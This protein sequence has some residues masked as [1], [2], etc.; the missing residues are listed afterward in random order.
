M[1][2]NT[3]YVFD[4]LKMDAFDGH[5]LTSVKIEMLPENEMNLFF[6][7]DVKKMDVSKLVKSFSRYIDYEDIKSENVRGIVPRKWMEKLF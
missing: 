4:S 7:T 2:E 3:Y 5:T 6:K 1:I